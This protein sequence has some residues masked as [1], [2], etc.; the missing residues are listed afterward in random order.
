[1]GKYWVKEI[2]L[3]NT[4]YYQVMIRNNHNSKSRELKG[5]CY[6]KLSSAIERCKWEEMNNP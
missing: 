1:M 5:A 6:K 3:I 2:R 4:T